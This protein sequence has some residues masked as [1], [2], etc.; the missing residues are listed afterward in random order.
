[1]ND[2]D[3]FLKYDYGMTRPLKRHYKT[4]YYRDVVSNHALFLTI[5]G[6]QAKRGQ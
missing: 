1:M 3:D 5:G 6:R 2:K 4:L